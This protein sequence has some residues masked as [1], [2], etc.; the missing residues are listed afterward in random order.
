[1]KP[2]EEQVR[3]RI[4]GQWVHKAD[5]DLEAAESLLASKRALF[6][7]SCFHAQQA[8]EK[9][10]KAFLVRNQLD[11]PKTHDLKELLDL[12]E[13]VNSDLA[14]SLQGVIVLTRYGVEIRYPGDAPEPSEAEAREAF[15]LARSVR[16]A[17]LPALDLH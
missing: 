9:Y 8:T 17:V 1:M 5:I 12:A 13:P 3:R 2:P 15:D 6:Y 16:D 10:L 7:P 14:T 11:F 4:V